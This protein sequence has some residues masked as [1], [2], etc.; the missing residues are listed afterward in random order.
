LSTF[1]Q[2]LTFLSRGVNV[3]V[4]VRYSP[5]CP[6]HRDYP[7]VGTPFAPPKPGIMVNSCSKDP[8]KQASFCPI[9]QRCVKTVVFTPRTG[10]SLFGTGISAPYWFI[11]TFHTFRH[12]NITHFSSKREKAGPQDG[13]PPSQ[14]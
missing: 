13:Q 10:I 6:L 11:G 14:P 7:R 12:G 5:V 9:S 4:S 8:K 3:A 2:F 1:C